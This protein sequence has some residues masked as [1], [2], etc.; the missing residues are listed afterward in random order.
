MKKIVSLFAAAAMMLSA[1]FTAFAAL[2]EN[3]DPKAALSL[4]SVSEPNAAGMYTCKVQIDLSDLGD[5]SDLY[6]YGAWH[7][8]T[9]LH[10]FKFSIRGAA[11]MKVTKKAYTGALSDAGATG[12]SQKYTGTDASGFDFLF[13]TTDGTV[14]YPVADEADVE[15]K[16]NKCDNAVTF[17]F[18]TKA[19]TVNFSDIRVGYLPFVEDSLVAGSESAKT[20]VA[21]TG[22]SSFA[23]P[24]VE[25]KEL[26][27]SIAEGKIYDNGTVWACTIANAVNGLASLS[28]TVT[29]ENGAEK[30]FGTSNLSAWGGAGATEFNIGINTAKAGV[31]AN[32]IEAT[33]TDGNGATATDSASAVAAN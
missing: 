7:N 17:E 27:L 22:A 12:L 33:I 32:A 8:G 11:D 29:A 13:Q 2:P 30:T 25:E 4:V 10:Y 3:C 26:E 16:T 5:L 19:G 23:I 28:A 9:K 31:V 24:P 6:E 14:A 20:A 18:M 15:L 1:T 21:I